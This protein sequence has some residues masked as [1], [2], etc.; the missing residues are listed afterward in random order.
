MDPIVDNPAFLMVIFFV[1]FI[2]KAMFDPEYEI[3]D[4]FYGCDLH[5]LYSGLELYRVGMQVHHE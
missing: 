4:I 2:A 3:W 1:H 5:S